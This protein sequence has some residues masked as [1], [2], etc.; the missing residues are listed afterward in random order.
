MEDKA[1]KNILSDRRRREL[2]VKKTEQKVNIL[3][4]FLVKENLT[5]EEAKVLLKI[6]TEH[7]NRKMKRQLLDTPL[8]NVIR[9]D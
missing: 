2:L 5:L 8:E 3:I 6:T 1:E 4:D 9:K 7:L